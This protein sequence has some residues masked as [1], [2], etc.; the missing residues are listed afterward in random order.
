MRV[1]LQRVTE[2]RVE[3][4]GETVGETGPGFLLLVGVGHGDGETEAALLASKVA[5]LR[6]LRRE[7]P[8]AQ[9]IFTWNADSNEHMLAINKAMGFRPVAKWYE[10]QLH[11]S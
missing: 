7:Q 4:A 6:L 10:W 8:A 2:A 5:N 1:L 11:L 3:V 9:R